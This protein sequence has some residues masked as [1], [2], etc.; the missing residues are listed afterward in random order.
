MVQ[1][2][3]KTVKGY[4]EELPPERR[5]V[6]SRVLDVVRRNM[7]AGYEEGM[8][9]GMIGWQVPLARFPETCNGQPLMYA[10]LAAQKNAFS[11]YL[12]CAYGEP[13]SKAALA[14]A[15][16]DAGKKLDMGKSCVRFK[17]LDDLPLEAIGKFIGAVPVKDYLSFYEKAHVSQSKKNRANARG[18][19]P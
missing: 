9:F 3:A 19:K 15:F 2:T 6:F 7:P 14:Q 5:A 17:K 13:K 18:G 8:A 1:S 12:M 16:A 10:A 11:L 4:L